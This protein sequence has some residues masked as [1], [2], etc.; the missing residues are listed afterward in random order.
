MYHQ[1]ADDGR[2]LTS[3]KELEPLL[4]GS[5]PAFTKTVGHIRFFYMADEIW[6]GESSLVFIAGGEQLTAIIL[7]DGFFYMHVA[8][9]DFR[10]VDGALL[11]DVFAMLERT[12]PI[13]WH[14]PFEQLTV[15]PGPSVYPCG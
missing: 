11:D 2:I 5:F 7:D 12:V 9:H 1:Y 3:P 13:G 14:R 8:D 6:D 15:N 10:I 4:R